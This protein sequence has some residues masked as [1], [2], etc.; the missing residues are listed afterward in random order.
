[1]VASVAL[2]PQ[3]NASGDGFAL[4]ANG[5]LYVSE[6]PS[7][8]PWTINKFSPSLQVLL[9]TSPQG[10][11]NFND[12]M[13][14]LVSGSNLY[15]HFDTGTIA[16][17]DLATL[18]LQASQQEPGGYSYPFG[19]PVN[20]GA[21]NI[22][23]VVA[24]SKT[25]GAP[26]LLRK[27]DSG[28]VSVLGSVDV[29]GLMAGLSG[30][31][32]SSRLA[33]SNGNIYVVDASTQGGWVAVR[34]L[35]ASNLA[36]TGVSS[37]YTIAGLADTNASIRTGPDGNLYVAGAGSGPGGGSY[38]VL[39]YDPN[40]DFLSSAT[41]HSPVSGMDSPRDLA[42]LNSS[43]VF[44]TGASSNSAGNFDAVTKALTLGGAP[45][46]SGLLF[47]LAFQTNGS[48]GV[49]VTGASLSLGGGMKI[50]GGDTSGQNSIGLNG[51]PPIVL[52]AGLAYSHQRRRLRRLRQR[53]QSAGHVSR[54][55]QQPRH[56]HPGVPEI[57]QHLVERGGLHHHRDLRLS[58]RHR[59]RRCGQHVGGLQSGGLRR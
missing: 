50:I 49:V 17:Y 20:D 22:Y 11:Y 35:A 48:T 21:G 8:G 15:V 55:L 25:T 59:F 29:S 56:P 16:R 51:T 14:M 1:M 41:F 19:A 18:T 38:L 2:A 9:S 26:K 46:P 52:T 57:R 33:Y 3:F 36:Y 27:Y 4:D 42:V 24:T 31:S 43:T 28:L 45:P 10:A 30:G 7:T 54:R 58:G 6:G 44:V 12:P 32:P 13:R 40:L 34:E 23:D 39:K 53:W 5:N 37:T 47:G